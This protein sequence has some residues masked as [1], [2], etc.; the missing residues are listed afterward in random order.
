[1]NDKSW[2]TSG[3]VLNYRTSTEHK[4][5]ITNADKVNGITFFFFAFVVLIIVT[6]IFEKK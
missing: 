2:N 3:A 6:N 5:Q 4:A 1:M